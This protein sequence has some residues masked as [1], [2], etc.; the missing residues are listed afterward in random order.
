MATLRHIAI[1]LHVKSTPSC[2]I[3]WITARLIQVTVPCN[4]HNNHCSLCQTC[5]VQIKCIHRASPLSP[6]H[7]SPSLSSSFP[8]SPFSLIPYLLSP[9][10]F[11]LFSISFLPSS[12]PFPSLLPPSFPSLPPSF[13]LSS[14]LLSPLSLPPSTYPPSFPLSLPPLSI[15]PSSFSLNLPPY[16]SLPEWLARWSSVVDQSYPLCPSAGRSDNNSFWVTRCRSLKGHN[17]LCSF[18]CSKNI[19]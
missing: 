10:P 5:T 18:F 15:P 1:T 8:L 16:P 6:L 13:P 4:R 2:V 12:L 14:S 3:H 9:S 7:L 19:T 11:S 17:C